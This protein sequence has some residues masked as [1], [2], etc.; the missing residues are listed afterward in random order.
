MSQRVLRAVQNP[1]D[2]DVVVRD[3]VKDHV[4]LV[5]VLPPALLEVSLVATK[6]WIPR[7]EL[8]CL[9]KGCSIPSGLRETEALQ[10]I[11]GNF[12]KIGGRVG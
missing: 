10:R 8:N 6:V 7:Y 12:L 4:R 9:S 3:L 2:H 11:L 1:K 5:I